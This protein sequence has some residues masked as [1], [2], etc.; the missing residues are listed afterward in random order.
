MEKITDEN[1]RERAAFIAH[2]IKNP[3][4]VLKANVQ[5]IEPDYNGENKKSFMTIYECIDNINKLISENMDYIKSET[6]RGGSDAVKIMKMVLRK[7]SVTGKRNFG[8]KTDRETVPVRCEGKL[9]ESLF[10]NLIKNAVEATEEGD[11][12]NAEI[13]VRRGKAVIKI[14]DTGWH[15]SAHGWSSCRCGTLRMPTYQ[16]N[17]CRSGRTGW[18]LPRRSPCI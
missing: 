9:L 6:V 13:R 10:E 5:L 14:S 1:Q 2:E 16:S 11:E 8:F 4:A 3:L 15:R 12:I 18:S 7:Y 17:Q